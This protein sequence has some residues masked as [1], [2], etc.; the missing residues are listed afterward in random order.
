MS[1]YSASECTMQSS[2][3]VAMASQSIK[4]QLKN[5][6]NLSDS[7]T[8]HLVEIQRPFFA[9]LSSRLLRPPPEIERV[10][11]TQVVQKPAGQVHHGALCADRLTTHDAQCV[12]RLT[13]HD[14]QHADRLTT[15]D[16]TQEP[17]GAQQEN[18]EQ[19][20]T[21]IEVN[22]VPKKSL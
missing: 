15:H 19:D 10:V 17:E 20:V 5:N 7:Q 1:T 3:G 21:L 13:T 4:H 14:T 6:F 22:I 2:F 11:D 16:E 12:D 8:Q 9:R 18:V